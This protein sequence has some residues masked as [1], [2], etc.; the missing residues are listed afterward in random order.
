MIVFG[1][2]DKFAESITNVVLWIHVFI[3]TCKPQEFYQTRF[4]RQKTKSLKHLDSTYLRRMCYILNTHNVDE[5]S[6]DDT[7]P[8]IISLGKSLQ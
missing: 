5:C 7:R 4:L 6:G 8:V 3:S 2:F 1:T